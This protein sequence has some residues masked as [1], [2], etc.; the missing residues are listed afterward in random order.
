M[1]NGKSQGPV[2]DLPMTAKRAERFAWTAF[3]LTIA[4]MV[5][6]TVSGFGFFPKT[7]MQVFAGVAGLCGSLGWY[8]ARYIPSKQTMN[9]DGWKGHLEEE[10]E[11][12]KPA[13]PPSGSNV[14]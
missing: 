7:W 3:L 11:P 1:P 9:S 10:E 2:V 14:D 6:N 5:V 4:Q 13:P 8:L 12:A